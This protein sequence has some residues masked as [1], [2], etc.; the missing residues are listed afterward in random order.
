LRNN[1]CARDLSAF[2]H[3]F[4]DV[5][6]IVEESGIALVKFRNNLVTQSVQLESPK[7]CQPSQNSRTLNRRVNGSRPTP[8][9]GL[10]QNLPCPDAHRTI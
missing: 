8:N 6:H 1:G 7:N 10:V 2:K 5:F 4:G 3:S 9:A